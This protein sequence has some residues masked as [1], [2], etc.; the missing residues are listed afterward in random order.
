MSWQVAASPFFSFPGGLQSWFAYRH[1]I[2]KLVAAGRKAYALDPRGIG[3][4]QRPSTGYDLDTAASDMHAFLQALNLARA[5]G[6]DVVGHDLGTWIGYAH[7]SAYPQ[8]V[9]R[10]VLS[11]AT[12]P[13]VTPMA[14]IPSDSLNVKTWHF[15]LN[16]L[17]DLPEMLVSGH[18]RAYLSWLFTK[19]IRT[20]AFDPVAIDEYV[21]VF[22]APGEARAG[23]D[24]YRAMFS[25]SGLERMK[26]R[27]SKKL[28][29][30]VLAVGGEGSVG[31]GMLRAM[32]PVAENVLGAEIKD[33]GH[34][35]PDERP[36][37]FAKLISDFWRK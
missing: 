6:I 5:G 37:E 15:G 36:M 35:L 17:P 24:Y 10:L 12:I 30:R 34:Y 18:E 4:S 33:C 22:S 16:R 23:F 8:D 7:A 21:R 25:S 13:S 20:Y 14:E 31:E 27:A 2:R 28:A 1:M 11:E 29:M 26:E 3:D 32:Q 9:R 19:S